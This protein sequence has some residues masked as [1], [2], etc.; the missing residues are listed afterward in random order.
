[1]MDLKRETLDAVQRA[2]HELL[3]VQHT[4]PGRTSS[5]GRTENGVFCKA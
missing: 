2:E 4:G 1:M 5:N 3:A